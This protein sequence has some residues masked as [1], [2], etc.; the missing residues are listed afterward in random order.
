MQSRVISRNVERC[1]RF[2]CRVQH[3][4]VKTA[5][6]MVL[7]LSPKLYL[8]MLSFKPLFKKKPVTSYSNVPIDRRT[9]LSEPTCV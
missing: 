4:C 6:A 7:T 8:R 3:S 1:F 5:E 9:E 2:I